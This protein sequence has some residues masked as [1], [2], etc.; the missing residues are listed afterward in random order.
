MAGSAAMGLTG[1]L[2]ELRTTASG[3]LTRPLPAPF[4]APLRGARALELGGPSAPFRRDGVLP[5]YALCAEV[6]GL[7]YAEDT[8]WHGRQEAGRYAPEG[9]PLGAMHIGDA[10]ELAGLPDG[11]YDVILHAHVL[12]HLA[13]PLRALARWREVLRPGGHLVM[14]VPHKEGT[15]DHR[16]PVTPLAHLE[17]DL[18]A[19]TGEDDL[20][21]LEETLRLHDRG[22]DAGGDDPEAFERLRRD[23]A[24][25]R[26][27]HHHVFTTPSLLALLDRAGVQLDAV[28]ARL[29]HDIFVAGHFPAGGDRPDHAALLARPPRSPF[30]ADR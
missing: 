4:T 20:T 5:A 14:V 23:N 12:E 15:F 9:R 17:A 21:H 19:G 1:K 30:R 10:G 29:P 2:R 11:S 24:A 18:V 8:I 27:L 13:N 3:D 22:R 16:R 28:E 6:D 7:Q 25:T 26:L